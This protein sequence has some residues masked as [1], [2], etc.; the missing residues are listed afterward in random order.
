[1][2]KGWQESELSVVGREKGAGAAGRGEVGGVGA[3]VSEEREPERE[4]SLRF[5]NSDCCLLHY[6][7]F[8]G[9]LCLELV[10]VPLTQKSLGS[11]SRLMYSSSFDSPECRVSRR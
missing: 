8:F 11:F 10:S 4:G 2:E 7:P 6:G 9:V 5:G 1:M 3:G